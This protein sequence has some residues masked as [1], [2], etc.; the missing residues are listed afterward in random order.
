MNAD[1]GERAGKERSPHL[2]D[3]AR[4]A[5]REFEEL[6]GYDSERVTG[7][8]PEEHGWSLLLDVLELERVPETTSIL[9]TYRVD[10]DET[11]HVR[12]YERLRRFSRNATDPGE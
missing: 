7:A 10:T 4:C 9:A 8:R 3:A 12:S 6:S 1:N 5:V 11:G 2:S